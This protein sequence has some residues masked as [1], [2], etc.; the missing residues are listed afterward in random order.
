MPKEKAGGVEEVPGGFMF[1]N[2][3]PKGEVDPDRPADGAAN[4]GTDG[5]AD[6]LPNR[7]RLAL[8]VTMEDD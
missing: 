7:D 2:A 3:P 4:V 6:E 5:C 1:K 8:S